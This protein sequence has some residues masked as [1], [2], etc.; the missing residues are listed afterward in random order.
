MSNNFS[1]YEKGIE[2]LN[3]ILEKME[4]GDISLEEN[5]LLYEEGIKLHDKLSKIL[6]KE[7]GKVKMIS[8]DN[9]NEFDEI[10][11]LND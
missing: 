1:N 5:V 7:E 4:N 2:R 11:F 3:E 9:S 6:D 10:N 8:K